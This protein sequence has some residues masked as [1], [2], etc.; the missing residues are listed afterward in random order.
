MKFS[1]EKWDYYCC[2]VFQEGFLWVLMESLSWWGWG[3]LCLLFLA[4]EVERRRCGRNMGENEIQ[5]HF[6]ILQTNIISQISEIITYNAM[7][8]LKVLFKLKEL[9]L[10]KLWNHFQMLY[11]PQAYVKFKRIRTFVHF[12]SNISTYLLLKIKLTL[13]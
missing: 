10:L 6:W 5:V 3:N 7:Y 11:I 8:L 1:L 2:K 12:I 4:C 13:V 9:L